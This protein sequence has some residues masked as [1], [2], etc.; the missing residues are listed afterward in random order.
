MTVQH[1][2]YVFT[3]SEWVPLMC[4]MDGGG[5]WHRAPV[6]MTLQL[7]VKFQGMPGLP[8]D[9]YSHCTH[10]LRV[11]KS[12]LNIDKDQETKRRPYIPDYFRP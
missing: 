2:V 7:Q 6:G 5:Y 8:G 9:L 12:G 4:R 1:Q 3:L 10:D 11:M